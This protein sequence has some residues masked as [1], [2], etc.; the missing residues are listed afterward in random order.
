MYMLYVQANK[1]ILTWEKNDELENKLKNITM[2]EKLFVEIPV[3]TNMNAQVMLFVPPDI[4][5]TGNVKYPLL[6]NV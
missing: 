1:E 2:P 3:N 5:K 6:V 4:V